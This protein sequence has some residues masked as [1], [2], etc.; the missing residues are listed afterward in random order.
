M[1]PSTR[2]ESRV[3]PS[4]RPSHIRMVLSAAEDEFAHLIC[5]W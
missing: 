2:L 1:T 3:R 5:H 4:H